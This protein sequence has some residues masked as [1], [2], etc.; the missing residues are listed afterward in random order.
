MIWKD[1][2]VLVTG[3]ASLIGSHLVDA[4]LARGASV[5]VVDNLSSGKLDNISQHFQSGRVEFQNQDLLDPRV[6]RQA[7]D[8]VQIVFHLAADHG[9]RGY[10]DLHQSA[11]ASNFVLDGT[12]FRAA[13]EAGVEKI[14]YASSGCIYP[15]FLQQDTSELLYLREDMAGPPYD[16]D[17]VYG[18]A[19]LCGEMTLKAYHREHGCR[20]PAAATSRYMA[21]G[22]SRTTP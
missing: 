12:V 21:S 8:G 20:P 13:Y 11:C 1:R 14:V 17:N 10:V 9:G 4:L 19:K 7:M 15:N 22:V 6:T 5:R 3:G 18:W 16:A 2:K